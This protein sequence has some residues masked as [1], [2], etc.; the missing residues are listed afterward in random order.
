[1]FGP[2]HLPKDFDWNK[3]EIDCDPSKTMPQAV[4][5]TMAIEAQRAVEWFHDPDD[6][7]LGDAIVRSISDNEVRERIAGWQAEY[8]KEVSRY[9]RGQSDA[10]TLLRYE[11]ADL[12]FER[13]RSLVERWERIWTDWQAANSGWVYKVN[14]G[15]VHEKYG[16]TGGPDGLT[17]LQGLK[18]M[19]TQADQ[20]AED[21]DSYG[22]A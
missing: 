22:V 16:F 8:D 17:Y 14:I 13:Q 3:L 4:A 6:V 5:D 21:Y 10:R 9:N 20:E 11:L 12:P 1:M 15:F 19:Y 18:T 2:V 7:Y